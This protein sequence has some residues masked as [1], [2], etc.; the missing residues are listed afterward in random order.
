M[1]FVTAE[2]R[3]TNKWFYDNGYYIS[4]CGDKINAKIAGYDLPNPDDIRR[5]RALMQKALPVNQRGL[6]RTNLDPVTV[7]LWNDYQRRQGM[8]AAEVD[9]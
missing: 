8:G 2:I 7:E 4:M 6:Y 9:N 3:R 1:E 5:K